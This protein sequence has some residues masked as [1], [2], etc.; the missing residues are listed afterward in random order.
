[1]SKRSKIGKEIAKRRKILELDIEDLSD[2]SGV[3]CS[4]ISNIET[5]KS[6]PTIKTLGKILTPLGLELFVRTKQSEI[7]DNAR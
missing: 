3:T 2:F 1:M 5:G 6:N 4:S 7:I